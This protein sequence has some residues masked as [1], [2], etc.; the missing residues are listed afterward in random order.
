[1]TVTKGGCQP[2]RVADSPAAEY[3]RRVY[4]RVRSSLVTQICQFW[5]LLD[6]PGQFAAHH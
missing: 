3:E 4:G 6:L 1:M 2:G 5:A